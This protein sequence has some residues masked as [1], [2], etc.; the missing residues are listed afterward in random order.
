MTEKEFEALLNF[1]INKFGGET[2]F[3]M[4][5]ASGKKFDASRQATERKWQQAN[6]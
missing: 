1:N 4:I 6:G 3:D 2:G 5:V